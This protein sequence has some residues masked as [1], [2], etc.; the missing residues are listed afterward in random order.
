MAE[1]TALGGQA[2]QL[3]R[4]R[5][6]D[7]AFARASPLTDEQFSFIIHHVDQGA[8]HA[9][10]LTLLNDT[11]SLKENIV[12]VEETILYITCNKERKQALLK[13]AAKYSWGPAKPAPA[14]KIYFGN[15]EGL[16]RERKFTDE[17]RAF[18]LWKFELGHRKLA[19]LESFN[20][21]FNTQFSITSLKICLTNIT[22]NSKAAEQLAQ[23][24]TTF[25]WWEP[26][27]APGS[28]A[29]VRAARQLRL[30]QARKRHAEKT[31]IQKNWMNGI[32]RF[33]SEQLPS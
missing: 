6:L 31:Q 22:K 15:G 12:T 14:P 32:G 33:E 25:G 9:D 20:T 7:T 27:P 11:F 19:I 29:G 23:Y 30:R 10:I 26:P 28:P 24:A 17:M 18:I 5:V 3:N 2:P 21:Q 8:A 1:N 13:R 16:D 4:I